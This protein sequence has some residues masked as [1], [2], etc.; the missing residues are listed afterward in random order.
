MTGMIVSDMK[1][2][3]F[4][5]WRLESDEKIEFTNSIAEKIIVHT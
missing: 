3:L 5:E 4:R 1:P 2:F